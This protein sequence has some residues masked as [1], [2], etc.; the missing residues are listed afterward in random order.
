MVTAKNAYVAISWLPVKPLLANLCVLAPTGVLTAATAGKRR[1]PNLTAHCPLH[2]NGDDDESK[3]MC[4]W[5]L[6]PPVF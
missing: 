2:E 4:F 6:V 1:D 5:Q 3:S